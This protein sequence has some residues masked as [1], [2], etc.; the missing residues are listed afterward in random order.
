[1]FG[2]GLIVA[3]I[4]GLLWFSDRRFER[5]V[6]QEIDTLFQAATP[7][8]AEMISADDLPAPV[9][10]Y[11]RRTLE[12]NQPYMQQVRLK[13]RGTIR[14]APDQPWKPFTAEQY[15][16]TNPP[17]FI[18]VADLRFLPG[19]WV[20]A[21]DKYMQRRGNML[22]KLLSTITIA[23]A[24]GEKIDPSALIRY[25][26]EMMWFPT[27]MLNQ[28]YIRWEAVDDRTARAIARDYEVSLTFHFD[29]NDDII[30]V[31]SEDRYLNTNDPQPT[32]WI[33]HCKRYQTVNGMRL[34]VEVEVGWEPESGYYGWWRGKVTA[35]EYNKPK[36]Y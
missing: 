5:K 2:I 29:E 33:G 11:F 36:R 7:P 22:I 14:L 35:I 9:R 16:T 28:R 21:R 17:G 24:K 1:M 6:N 26:A 18:W 23:N 4:A 15:F 27:A 20:K 12:R 8:D 3:L 30:K 34:P 31:V 32:R 19:V 25:M 10:R 13:Q